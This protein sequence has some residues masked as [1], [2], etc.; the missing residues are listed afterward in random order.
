MNKNDLIRLRSKIEATLS[1]LVIAVTAAKSELRESSEVNANVLRD[2]M[3]CAKAEVDLKT[4]LEIHNHNVA[5]QT[6]L[7]NALARI[8]A[9]TFGRC[10]ECTDEIEPRRIEAMPE[11][12]LCVDCQS[13][14][15]LGIAP[16]RKSRPLF[17]VPRMLGSDYGEV[18]RKFA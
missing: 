8:D 13:C 10:T 2:E 11:A 5:Q 16:E 4:T 9:G 3:D 18:R 1:G 14:R 12:S 15:E 7:Q 17:F 6:R